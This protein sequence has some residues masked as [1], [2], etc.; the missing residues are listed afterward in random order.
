M[1]V[2]SAQ[3]AR[4]G[5][6]ID[7]PAPSPTDA[8]ALRSDNAALEA[9]AD[10]LA[11][12]KVSGAREI[13]RARREEVARRR[14]A[15]N[16]VALGRL[17]DEQKAAAKVA[18]DQANIESEL[19]Q[20]DA[21]IGGGRPAH[22]L[23]RIGPQQIVMGRLQVEKGANHKQ[24]IDSMV[25]A[26][27]EQKAVE[28]VDAFEAE[29]NEF[30][31]RRQPLPPRLMNEDEKQAAWADRHAQRLAMNREAGMDDKN[32]AAEAKADDALERKIDRFL[33]RWD[34]QTGTRVVQPINWTAFSEED[35][36]RIVSL[37]RRGDLDDALVEQMVNAPAGTL[38]QTAA[39]AKAPGGDPKA[40]A[41][42][43]YDALPDDQKTPEN[44]KRIAAKHGV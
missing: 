26:S 15:E 11:K 4:T 7:T 24:V 34:S 32:A 14:I 30:L 39:P 10:R 38:P 19:A 9:Y 29:R 28:R 40:A 25:A 3:T 36:R 20:F 44:A 41:R 8:A 1:R 21:A 2:A 22:E 33:Y 23:A 13:E 37:Y 31:R 17:G 18:E 35:K 42:A 6:P 43:E 27:P 12:T 5:S 16:N